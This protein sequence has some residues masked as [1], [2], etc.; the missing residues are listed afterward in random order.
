MRPRDVVTSMLVGTMLVL[1]AGNPAEAGEYWGSP[2]ADVIHGSGAVDWVYAAAGDDY[3]AGY[4]GADALHGQDGNDRLM[5]HHG[6]DSLTGSSGNDILSGGFGDDLLDPEA[7]ADSVH[8][9]GGDDAVV[10][11]LD[12]KIDQ[13]DCGAGIDTVHDFGPVPG[14]DP[15]D[16]FVDCEHFEP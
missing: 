4:G 16:V 2:A 3:A 7:G 1:A 13:V 14:W 6:N 12:H 11:N 10:V 5:G 15:Q 9:G 8:G